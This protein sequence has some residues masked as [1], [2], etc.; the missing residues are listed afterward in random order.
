[1][2]LEAC[3]DKKSELLSYYHAA[4]KSNGAHRASNPAP[5]LKDLEFE[6][7][8]RFFF[9][10]TVEKPDEARNELEVSGDRVDGTPTSDQEPH[11]STSSLSTEIVVAAFEPILDQLQRSLAQSTSI[12]KLP[13]KIINAIL[14]LVATQAR[15]DSPSSDSGN[16]RPGR[17]DVVRSRK[18]AAVEET[19]ALRYPIALPFLF[20]RL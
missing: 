11:C 20:S 6:L 16:M 15:S 18:A 10:A 1:M 5:T 4:A 7:F 12:P 9:Q 19:R 17:Q 3:A 14:S 2:A 8:K 13:P